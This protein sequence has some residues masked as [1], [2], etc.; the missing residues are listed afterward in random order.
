[1]DIFT[2][3]PPPPQ[4]KRIRT[5]PMV[6]PEPSNIRRCSDELESLFSTTSAS[7]TGEEDYGIDGYSHQQCIRFSKFQEE[8]WNVLCDAHGQEL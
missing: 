7:P 3:E 1:M 5:D 8:T 4:R 6:K 2:G